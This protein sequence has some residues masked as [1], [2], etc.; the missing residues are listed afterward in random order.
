MKS[1]VDVYP[2]DFSHIGNNAAYVNVYSSS[3]KVPFDIKRVFTVTALEKCNRGAHAHKNC[4]QLLICIHGECT[5]TVRD[6]ERVNRFLL[7][8]PKNG[9]LVP[10][11]IWAEQEY[12][13]DTIL[14]VITDRPYE[15]DDYIRDYN[16]FLKWR[17]NT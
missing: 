12:N 17:R 4:T 11:S 16:E 13:K 7:N 2:I 15:E 6:G 5:L 1:T 3:D 14:M 10:P 8:S 9:I